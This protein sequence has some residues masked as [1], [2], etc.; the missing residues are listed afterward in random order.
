MERYYKKKIFVRKVPKNHNEIGNW[1]ENIRQPW[2]TQLLSS[3]RVI[4][5]SE[6]VNPI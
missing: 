4:G 5:R 6:A 3:G 2:K 1:I